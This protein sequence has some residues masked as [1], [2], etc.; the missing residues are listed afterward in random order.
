MNDLAANASSLDAG[1]AYYGRQAELSE[2]PRIHAP[3]LLHYAGEDARINAGIDAYRQA[4]EA[5]KKKFTI[6]MYE[7]AQACVSTTTPRLR[8]TTRWQPTSPGE[9]TTAFLKQELT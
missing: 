7:G 9:R 5:A 2:V 8:A 4:L 6:H 1:V 3:L